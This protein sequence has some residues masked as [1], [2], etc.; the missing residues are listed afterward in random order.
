M[1]RSAARLFLVLATACTHAEPFRSGDPGDNGPFPGPPPTRLT[2]NPG[3]DRSP[4][5]SPGGGGIVYAFEQFDRADRDS[6]LGLLPPTGGTR[7]AE[8]CPV[9]DPAGDSANAREWPAASPS[10]R[11]AWVEQQSPAGARAPSTGAI[12]IGTLDPLGPAAVV[13]T[14]PYLAA[15]G[16]VHA[17]VTHL[18][19]LGEDTLV[20]V[21]AELLYTRP[22]DGC[23]VDTLVVG[24]EI[25]TLDIL[26]APAVATVVLG[27]TGATAVWPLPGDGAIVYTL[28][29]D[30]KVYRRQ[31]ATGTVDTLWD[32][33]SQGI[34]RDPGVRGNRLTAIVGGR[35]QALF[36]PLLG[37]IQPDSG[38]TLVLL[39]LADSTVTDISAPNLL[40]RHA[41]PAP[42]GSG[43]VAEA[44]ADLGPYV[45]DLYL[46]PLP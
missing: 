16:S 10:G 7:Q 32:F 28:V 17:T 30:R 25:V 29:G 35:V 13:R 27:T 33:V 21:G 12:R 31:L 1:P 44:T 8:R 42:D 40:V 9:G 45:P 43:V 34:A 11:L 26:G 24:R 18:G 3:Q 6:C 2:L 39:D 38:G 37:P 46:F 20:Y 41:T 23:K 5:W 4:A 15:S 19:W 14:L 22:C 36:D